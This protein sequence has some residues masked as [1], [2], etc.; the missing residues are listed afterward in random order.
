MKECPD[1]KVLNSLTNRCVNIDGKIGKKILEKPYEINISWENNSC[2]IDSLF[3]SLFHFKNRVVHN[4]FF[5][6]LLVNEYSL[7]IQREIFNIYKYI[8]KNENIQNKQCA[9]IRY[10]LEKYY[11]ELLKID[12]KNNKIFFNNT[13]NWTKEQIDIFELMTFLDKIFDFNNNLKIKDG[14]NKYKTNMIYPIMQTHLIKKK[15]F[16][17]STIIPDRIDIHNLDP[18]NYYINSEGKLIKYIE[19]EYKILKTNGIL[20]IEIYRNIGN[21]K[22]LTTKILYPK[23]IIIKEDKKELKLRSIILHKGKTV[24]SG[25]YTTI[26]KKDG[27]T[28]EYDDMESQKLTEITEHYEMSMQENIVCLVYSR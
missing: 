10:Y 4:M 21:N 11:N 28:Y 14:N 20:F 27:K 2:Y 26:I 5:K 24:H 1:K 6:K 13:D 25:H 9:A 18:N 7:K 19:K 12:A 17:I 23:S 22:K 15:V 3:V 16:D 8:N